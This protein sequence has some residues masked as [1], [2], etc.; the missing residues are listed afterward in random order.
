MS[1]ERAEFDKWI[2]A[3]PLCLG[4]P[5][6]DGGL[7]GMEHS[8]KCPVKTPGRSTDTTYFDAYVAGKRAGDRELMEALRQLKTVAFKY[9]IY[10]NFSQPAISEVDAVYQKVERL[11]TLR[12]KE[13]E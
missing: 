1:E 5:E 11:L 3:Q 7:V 8:E 6:C 12:A 4:Y 2:F 9:G 13:G 10:T